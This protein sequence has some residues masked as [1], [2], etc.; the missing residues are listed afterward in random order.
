MNQAIDNSKQSSILSHLLRADFYRLWHHKIF[1]ISSGLAFATGL[2]VTIFFAL[3]NRVFS[4]SVEQM[5]GAP[6]TS[7]LSLELAAMSSIGTTGAIYGLIA[8]SIWAVSDFQ[9][10]VVQNT[11]CIGNSRAKYFFSKFLLACLYSAFLLLLCFLAALG[12]A[13]VLLPSAPG[14]ASTVLGPQAIT[15]ATLWSALCM[16]MWQYMALGA[17]FTAIAFLTRNIALSLVSSFGV[18]LLLPIMGKV[19]NFV[20]DRMFSSTVN[21]SQFL[22]QFYIGAIQPEIDNYVLN[23]IGIGAIFIVLSAVLAF[24]HFKYSDV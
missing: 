4:S 9:H 20:G 3:M 1:W 16:S 23:G 13:A 24:A 22:P 8:I 7:A 21:F 10:R 2:I 19:A 18:L 5:M 11:L 12:L 17:V 6:G 15:M 14:E